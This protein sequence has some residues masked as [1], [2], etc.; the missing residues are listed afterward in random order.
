MDGSQG[1]KIV[2]REDGTHKRAFGW[3]EENRYVESRPITDAYG[4]LARKSEADRASSGRE[5][6]CSRGKGVS[7]FKESA[8]G[9]SPRGILRDRMSA[10]ARGSG[11][12]GSL[13]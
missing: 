8:V 5:L 4:T 13:G 1:A 10:N 2:K 12:R 9:R 11:V 3:R 7:L 6:R